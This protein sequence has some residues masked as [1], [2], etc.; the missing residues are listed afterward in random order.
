MTST[1]HPGPPIAPQPVPRLAGLLGDLDDLLRG[2]G[3]VRVEAAAEAPARPALTIRRLLK[4][5]VLLGAIYGASLGTYGLINGNELAGAQFV[6]ATIKLP[7][8][9]GLTLLVTFPS[10]YVSAALLRLPFGRKETVRVLLGAIA[11]NLAV[12]ASLGP[13][14]VFFAASTD[15]YP[16][17]LL[18]NVAV[19]SAGGLI[20]LLILRRVA[21]E[22]LVHRKSGR[23]LLIAWCTVYGGVGAQMAWLLRPFLGAPGA[24]FQLLRARESSF[25]E[26][27]IGAIG[28]W[29]AGG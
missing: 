11:V 26:C 3:V 6:A 19:A 21:S 27:V 18:L 25:F 2:H 20:S 24:S 16:F 10:L 7:L 9:F 22:G 15:S 29:V 14:F 5:M 28:S 23:R 12:M 13:V 8:L 4:L 17:L 1:S